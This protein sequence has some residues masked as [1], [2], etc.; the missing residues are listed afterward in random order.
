MCAKDKRLAGDERI[1]GLIYSTCDVGGDGGRSHHMEWTQWT[2]PSAF[3]LPALGGMQILGER[4]R[5][6]FTCGG[7]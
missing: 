2:Q 6:A 5:D 4:E 3:S 7:L 1:P